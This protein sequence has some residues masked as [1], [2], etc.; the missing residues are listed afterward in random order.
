[1]GDGVSKVLWGL[2]GRLLVKLNGP[3]IR[4][5][6]DTCGSSVIVDEGP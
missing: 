6:V 4:G 3:P 5:K 1:M 2:P